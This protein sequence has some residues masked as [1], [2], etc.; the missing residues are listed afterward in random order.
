MKKLFKSRSFRYGGF[1]T[2]ITLGFVVI[3]IVLNM[4]A[5]ALY[6]RFPLTVDLTTNKVFTVS[7]KSEDYLKTVQSVLQ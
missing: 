2:V 1:A 7:Q 3:M 5:T 6:E 4:L